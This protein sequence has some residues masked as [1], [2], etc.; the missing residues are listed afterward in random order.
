MPRLRIYAEHHYVIG[1]LVLRQQP[2]TCRV[3]GE[4]PRRFALSGLVLQASQLATRRV[5]AKD[6]NAIVAAVR[7]VNEFPG[8]MDL[9]LRAGA[10]AG[11]PLR[12]RRYCLQ[13]LQRAPLGVVGKDGERGTHLVDQEHET[14]GR[15]KREVAWS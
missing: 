13:F 1:I 3:E 11:E 14:A 8:W 12:K 15:M 7:A 5:E 4:V 10:V 2:M 9:H 6:S